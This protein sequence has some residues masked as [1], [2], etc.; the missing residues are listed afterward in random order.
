MLHMPLAAETL[1][2]PFQIKCYLLTWFQW[3]NKTLFN[4]LTKHSSSMENKDLR[5]IFKR[6]AI[7]A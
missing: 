2:F 6:L 3:Q 4:Q 7:D 1:L 5:R